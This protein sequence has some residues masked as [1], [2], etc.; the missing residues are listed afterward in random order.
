[1]LQSSY[2]FS[3]S[4]SVVGPESHWLVGSICPGWYRRPSWFSQLHHAEYHLSR[5]S[6]SCYPPPGIQS[7]INGKTPMGTLVPLCGAVKGL[8]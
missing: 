7:T 8:S 2:S 3:D 5:R 1:M 6:P 4:E